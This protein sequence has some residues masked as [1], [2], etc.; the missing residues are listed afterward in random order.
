MQK[1]SVE[2]FPYRLPAPALLTALDHLGSEQRKGVAPRGRRM[3]LAGGTQVPPQGT[4]P[5]SRS[6]ILPKTCWICSSFAKEA[7]R[8]SSHQSP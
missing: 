8:G 5:P 7:K 4:E 6:L 2:G 1:L 3:C